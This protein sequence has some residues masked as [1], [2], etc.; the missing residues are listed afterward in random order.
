MSTAAE[1]DRRAG[2]E[3]WAGYLQL[4]RYRVYSRVRPL[5]A[6]ASACLEGC[7]RWV[8]GRFGA[9]GAGLDW[10]PPVP[11]HPTIPDRRA[12]QIQIGRDCP[13]QHLHRRVGGDGGGLRRRRR[14][15]RAREF[16]AGAG[17]GDTTGGASACMHVCMFAC[18]RIYMCVYIFACM[19]VYMCVCMYVCMRVCMCVCM[20][21]CM[22]VCMYVR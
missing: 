13:P 20:C 16:D 12:A 17:T 15:C 21:V 8:E 6:S 14:R 10:G 19:R 4:D 9:W 7:V 1:A 11:R 3:P 5:C 22:Y 18:M 2:L